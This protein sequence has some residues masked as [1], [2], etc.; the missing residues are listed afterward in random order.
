MEREFRGIPSR[1]RVR[2]ALP[3]LGLLTLFGGLGGG[4]SAFGLGLLLRG[5]TLRVGLVLLGLALAVQIIASGDGAGDL[6]RLAL[7]SLDDTP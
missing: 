4:T 1:P 2:W 5:V 6:F 3:L 7:C